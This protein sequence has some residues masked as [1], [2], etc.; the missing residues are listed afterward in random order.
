MKPRESDAIA[1]VAKFL[2]MANEKFQELLDFYKE[3]EELRQKRIA[4]LFPNGYA[5][6]IKAIDT[7]YGR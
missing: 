1:A 2:G 3:E 6:A 5:E 7:H 4:L